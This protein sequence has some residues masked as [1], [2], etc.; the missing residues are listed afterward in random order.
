METHKPTNKLRIYRTFTYTAK[1]LVAKDTIQQF[2]EAY[3][4][5][6]PECRDEWR[7]IPLVVE[8]RKYE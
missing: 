1:G 4:T 8:E 6:K 5:Y 7:D 3:F 2:F